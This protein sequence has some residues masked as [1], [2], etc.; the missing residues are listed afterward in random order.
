MGNISEDL[1]KFL[2]TEGLRIIIDSNGIKTKSYEPLTVDDIDD[3]DDMDLDNLD[4]D[5]LESL[6]S[7]A[8]DLQ[9]EL[10]DDE[11]DDEGSEVHNLWKSRLFE[12]EDFIDRIQDRLD[13]REDEDG[14]NADA[15]AIAEQITRKKET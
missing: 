9:D 10:E 13:E 11:P 2:K 7:K 8:E 12:I 3:F 1:D 15:I 4:I 14:E 5:A 6:M